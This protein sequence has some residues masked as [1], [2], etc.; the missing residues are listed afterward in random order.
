MILTISAINNN[1]MFLQKNYEILETSSRLIHWNPQSII[2]L[3]LILFGSIDRRL[4]KFTPRR[5]S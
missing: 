5:L 1:I 4:I 3:R 2:S